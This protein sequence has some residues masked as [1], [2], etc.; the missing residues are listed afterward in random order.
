MVEQGTHKPLVGSSTLP[1]GTNPHDVRGPRRLDLTRVCRSELDQSSRPR[2][3]ARWFA[4]ATSQGLR[5]L[6]ELSGVATPVG[7]ASEAALQGSD[8]IEDDEDDYDDPIN[9]SFRR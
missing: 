3:R 2:A 8:R 7:L 4:R 9:D 6:A 5:R 1:P